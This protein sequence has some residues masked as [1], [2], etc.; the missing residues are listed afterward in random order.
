MCAS[1]RPAST[2]SHSASE[3][4]VVADAIS[5]R[6][7]E[8]HRCGVERMRDAVIVIVSMEMILFELRGC[9]GTDEFKQILPLVK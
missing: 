2:C 6:T 9:A 3:P 4:F 1:R 7:A 5:S 8:N